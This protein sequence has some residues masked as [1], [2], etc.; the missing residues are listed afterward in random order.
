[1]AHR[2]QADHVGGTEGARL[3]A[4]ELGAG[5]VVDD[6]DRQAE[7]LG[8]VDGRQ[9]AEDAD[10]VGD[11]VRGVLGAHDAL[12]EGR[13]QEAFEL[14][15]DGRAGRRGRDDLDQVHV[16]RRIEEVDAAE[17]RLQ[18]GVEAVGQRGDRQA[19]GVRGE[20]RV[21][22]DVRRDLLV[23]VVLPVHALGDRFDDQV[24]AGEQL[25]VVFV[26]GDLD[27]R[28][29]FLVAERRRAEFLQVLDRAQHD[30]VLVAFLGGQV[31]QHHRHLGVDAVG[32]DLRAHHTG[33]QHGDFFND[34]IGHGFPLLNVVLAYAGT[35]V[36]SSA[37]KNGVPALARTTRW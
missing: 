21:R 15:D 27:Q 16:A 6:V 5:Q 20:D 24:A 28:G 36:C 1:M 37:A 26:V 3:G 29:V 22:R 14:V 33:A 32:G 23:Q 12:A 35:Q 34:E 30:A 18:F 2:V 7:L 11:E 25:E 17:A 8:F 4:T 19:R 9:H 31:E 10:A 13:G